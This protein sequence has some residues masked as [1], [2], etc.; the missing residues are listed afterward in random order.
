M[1]R[2]GEPTSEYHREADQEDFLV[3]LGEALLIIEGEERQ[4]RAW[5]FVHCP[6]N[7]THLII[8]AGSGP[9]LVIA[10]GARTRD[11]Q[12]ESLGFTV[13]EVATRDGASVLS[14]DDGNVESFRPPTSTPAHL[15][16]WE[17]VILY[18]CDATELRL[19]G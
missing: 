12:P 11:G 8:G 13:D 7:A 19:A 17:G 10:V 14:L 16:G 2:P 9:C 4:L 5:D 6:P 18:R 15:K 3:V 1:L